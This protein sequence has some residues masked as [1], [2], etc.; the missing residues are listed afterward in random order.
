MDS[1]FPGKLE[2]L[3]AVA[4]KINVDVLLLK[5]KVDTC[6]F[7]AAKLDQVAVVNLAPIIIHSNLIWHLITMTQAH[8][9][10][11]CWITV[12]VQIISV[13][14]GRVFVNDI[15]VLYVC[16]F[17]W[18]LK[19]NTLSHTHVVL[20]VRSVLDPALSR[21]ESFLNS[22]RTEETTGHYLP[23]IFSI[24]LSLVCAHDIIRLRG[25]HTH[26]QSRLV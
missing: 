20:A 15:H 21:R 4:R 23:Q 11:G 18:Q 16:M 5:V 3:K 22:R 26:T 25:C 9:L 7:T 13:C 24:F 14:L 19:R 6:S 10:S 12:C 8:C 17:I 2:S 1:L